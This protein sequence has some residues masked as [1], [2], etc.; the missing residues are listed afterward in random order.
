[1]RQTLLA[2]MAWLTIGGMV[3]AYG[4]E[5]PI[6]DLLPLQGEWQGTEQCSV[7]DGGDPAPAS[8]LEVIIRGNEIYNAFGSQG[9]RSNSM[10]A[11]FDGNP[12][13]TSEAPDFVDASLVDEPASRRY[14][15]QALR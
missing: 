7:L 2:A 4:D 6:S 9:Q 13:L 5:Q 10:L 15:V 14:T 8:P 1:M 11:H 12:D 3:A